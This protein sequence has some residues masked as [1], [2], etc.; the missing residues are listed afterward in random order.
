MLVGEVREIVR[1]PVKS[2]YGE[3]V[4]T[5]TIERYGLYGDRSHA[6]LD[7]TRDGKFLTATQL[8][9]MVGYRARF[10]D[11]ESREE[12]PGIQ[13]TSPAGHTYQ[14]GDEALL[15]E[16]E[17]LSGRR[18][19]A[20]RY[21]PDNVPAGAIEEEHVLITTDAS[22]AMLQETWGDTIDNRRFRG[23]ICISLDNR[24]P[25]LEETWFGKRM[26][27]GGTELRVKR[28]CER[29]M[30]INIDPQTGMID[31][32]L[33]KIVAQR[34]NNHFGVYASVVQTGEIHVGDKVYIDDG[35]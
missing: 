30:I 1:H 26:S 22:L 25:F 11:P 9:A 20:V 21:T 23:N 4:P 12:F 19:S 18:V 31:S 27:I 34:R 10:M 8:P 15:K 29:C 17:M 2:F 7:E 35:R 13:I 32:S 33:L 14:W 6:F 16:M 24:Q 5:T 3:S 28:H